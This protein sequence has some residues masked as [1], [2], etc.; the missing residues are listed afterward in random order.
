M[1]TTNVADLM[2]QCIKMILINMI[3]YKFVVS[4]IK[5]SDTASITF[6]WLFKVHHL[7]VALGDNPFFT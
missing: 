5:K 1:V 7:W 3:E 4:I 2:F 6:V